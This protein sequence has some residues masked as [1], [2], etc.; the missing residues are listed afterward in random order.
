MNYHD[1]FEKLD[2]NCFPDSAFRSDLIIPESKRTNMVQ[3]ILLFEKYGYLSI[4]EIR[5]LDKL[6]SVN[7]LYKIGAIIPKNMPEDWG[8]EKSPN[9]YKICLFLFLGTELLE[10]A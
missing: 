2:C 6:S 3:T 7:Q 4:S 1:F 10:D 5:S 8:F 9:F